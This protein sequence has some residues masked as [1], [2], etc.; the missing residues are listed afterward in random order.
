MANELIQTGNYEACLIAS[1]KAGRITKD[2]AQEMLQSG[3]PDTAIAN[4]RADLSRKRRENAIQSVRMA[5]AWDN[6]KSHPDGMYAGLQS[7]MTKD[8]KG[9]AGYGN[10]E[11]YQKFYQ[12]KYHSRM[13]D[14]LSRF[15]TRM[16]GMSQD[17]EGLDK[18][19]AA[20]FGESVDDAD[21][22]RMADDVKGVFEDIRKDFNSQG[23]SISKLDSYN[24]PQ[25]H[26]MN[27]VKAAGKQEWIEQ[28]TPLLDRSRMVDD[29]GRPL[30]DANFAAAMDYVYETITTGGANKLKDFSS[31]GAVGKKLARKH[32]ERRFLHFKNSESWIAYN[33][34][35]GRG[36]NAF[37]VIAGHI[38]SMSHD[39]AMMR[40]MGT[41]PQT[42]Y[43]ALKFQAMRESE[44]T[45]RQQ[46]FA[47]DLFATASGSVDQGTMTGVADFMQSSRNL[48][49]AATLGSAFLSSLSDLATISVTSAYNS[50]PTM[51]VLKRQMSLLNPANEADRIAAVRM[52]LVAEAWTDMLNKNNRYA[53][54]YGNGITAKIADGVMR[55]SLLSPWTDAGRKAFG[56]EFSG[57]LADNFGKS[58]DELDDSLQKAFSTYGINADDWDL[59]RRSEP[60]DHKGA[61]FADISQDGGI[62]FHQMILSEMDYAVPTPDARTRAIT[63]QAEGRATITGQAWRSVMML[64]S[65]PITIANTHLYRI[66]SQATT[67]DRWRYGIAILGASTVMGGAALTLKDIAAGREPRNIEDD[68]VKFLG[69]AIA[70]GGGLGIFGDFLFSDVNRFGGGMVQTIVGPYGELI[71]TGFKISVGNIQ[72]AIR[73][74]ETNIIPELGQLVKRYQPKVWQTRL[75]QEGLIDGLTMMADPQYEYKLMRSMRKMSNEYGTDY[76]WRKGEILPEAVQ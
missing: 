56:M 12:G 33:E 59:F 25:H 27:A 37:D 17:K 3:D 54:T 26:D 9:N 10:I 19:V 38:D 75:F 42:T 65:F 11:Y 60:L 63:T 29:A 69:A 21:I 28:I 47:D 50:V 35:F 8:P 66:A 48:L 45:N 1:N 43:K 7:L 72:E 67:A 61:K 68:P 24:L 36:G 18:L 2:L 55:V 71:D 30:S 15:R 23:G 34:R 74:D 62:K 41:N 39:I 20:I 4:L 32:G 44:F 51:K 16:A 46:K 73:S 6:I 49:T 64:K 70:Q 57:M 14:V 40:L 53:D 13:A 31:V 22:A 52:G 58:I 76:W 5:E